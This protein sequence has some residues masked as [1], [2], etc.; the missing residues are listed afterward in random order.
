[1]REDAEN[2]LLVHLCAGGCMRFRKTL[3]SFLIILFLIVTDGTVRAEQ[4]T[5]QTFGVQMKHGQPVYPLPS[6]VVLGLFN[7]EDP[8]LDVAHANDGCVQV[9]QN[10]WNGLFSDAPVFDSGVSGKVATMQW[11]LITKHCRKFL[12]NTRS[13]SPTQ[14]SLRL[15]LMNQTSQWLV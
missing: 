1:M 12:K 10:F 8:F 5:L 9:F 6:N 7:P 11:R 3:L 2:Y 14:T 13:K 15:F 4:R